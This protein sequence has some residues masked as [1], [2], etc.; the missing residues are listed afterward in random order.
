MTPLGRPPNTSLSGT[1]DTSLIIAIDG[2]AA[3]GKIT[4][5]RAVAEI[6]GFTY[7]DSGAMY[8]AAALSA[9]RRGVPFDDAEE[10]ARVAEEARIELAG[11]GRGAVLLNDE[12]VTTAIRTREVSE[13]ASVVSTVPG[14]RRALVRQQRALG[15]RTHC[16][17]EGRD[18][19]TVVFPDADLK[20][21]LTAS[22]RARAL[23]RHAELNEDGI[24]L[25]EIERE[26]EDRDL[27]DTT[28]DD[29]P[30]RRADDAVVIDTASLTIEQ[31]VDRVVELARKRGASATGRGASRQ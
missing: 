2:P 6:L 9:I 23:R 11:L 3:S 30:L 1:R 28:R 19:G 20:I 5:A 15:E 25:D 18:I 10:L 8:R 24:S 13:A 21:F 7:I 22:A 14:V 26:I 16:V 31:Q 17:M 27:R 4:T 12:D 29:S